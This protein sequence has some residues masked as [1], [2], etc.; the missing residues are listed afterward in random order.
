MSDSI[1]CILLPLVREQYMLLPNESLAEIVTNR[2]DL[3]VMGAR[4]GLIGKIQW[5]G[6]SVPLISFEA[7]VGVGIP[8]YGSEARIAVLFSPTGDASLPY[9]AFSVQGAPKLLDVGETDLISIDG[10][11]HALV[12][13]HVEVDDKRC[14]IPNLQALETFVKLRVN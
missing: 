11:E 1:K 9:M 4:E 12:S 3:L 6:Y 14:M 7:A 8:S 13:S 5:R 10:E 2:S